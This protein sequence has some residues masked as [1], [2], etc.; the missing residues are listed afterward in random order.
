MKKPVKLLQEKMQKSCTTLIGRIL[1]KIDDGYLDV[2]GVVY[3]GFGSSA[4]RE[5]KGF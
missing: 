2:Y 1:K 3:D 5:S 4:I